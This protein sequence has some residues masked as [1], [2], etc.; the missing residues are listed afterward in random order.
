MF[1]VPPPQSVATADAVSLV[2]EMYISFSVAVAVKVTSTPCARI[3]EVVIL[4]SAIVTDEPAPITYKPLAPVPVVLIVSLEK[5]D[6]LSTLVM[7]PAFRPLVL[8]ESVQVLLPVVVI[9]DA[10]KVYTPKLETYT[11]GLS[12]TADE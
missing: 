9:V 12:F 2:V 7:M 5:E 10:V 1:I 8:L 6:L 11:P 3:P 4:L